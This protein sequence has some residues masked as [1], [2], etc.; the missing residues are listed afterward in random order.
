MPALSVCAFAILTSLGASMWAGDAPLK[1]AVTPWIGDI[2]A[3]VAAEQGLWEKQGLEVKLVNYQDDEDF[4]AAIKGGAIDLCFDMTAMSVDMIRDGTDLIL[5]AET[6]WSHGGDKVV[7]AKGT[8]AKDLVGKKIGIYD[9]GAA[10]N[11]VVDAW[12]TREGVDPATVERLVLVDDVLT[13]A[14]IAGKLKAIINYEPQA[15]RAV[16]EG[17]GAV[18]ATTADFPGIMP[19]GIAGKRG[20][21]PA[22]LQQYFTGLLQA[23][24]FIKDPA[25]LPAVTAAANAHLFKTEPQKPED[26]A[27]QI[28]SVKLH[29][30]AEMLERN[31]GDAGIQAFIVKV[32]TWATAHG[33]TKVDMTGRIDTSAAQAAAKALM[34]K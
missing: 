2:A 10:V 34:G 32:Q 27:D 31:A 17:G 22:R 21:P 6:D 8:S 13:E 3:A 15:G 16:R 30:P 20:V 19:E 28:A 4:R 12:L 18:A 33:Q 5:Y 9:E 26:I 29:G 11:L 7:V 14:F 24:A 1:V 25:N 23:V